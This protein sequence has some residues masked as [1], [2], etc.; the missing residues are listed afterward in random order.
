MKKLVAAATLLATLSFASR[1]ADTSNL[2]T[3][4]DAA[5]WIQATADYTEYGKVWRADPRD[6]KSANETLYSGN[7]GIV[8]FFIEAYRS[9]GDQDLLKEARDGADHLLAVFV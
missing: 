7:P 8:L 2:D 6:A 3:A 4:L 9:T 1:A 5:R